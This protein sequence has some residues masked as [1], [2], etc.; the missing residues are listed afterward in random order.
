MVHARIPSVMRHAKIL[1][2]LAIFTSA[3]AGAGED[4][5]VAYS[6]YRLAVSNTDV[7]RRTGE[8]TGGDEM[9][10]LAPRQVKARAIPPRLAVKPFAE[11]IQN[12]ASRAALDPALVHAVIDVESRYNPSARSPKGA[13]GLMQVMPATGLR[14]G[15][16]NP[17]RSVEANLRAGTRY[18]SDL[19]TL[20]DGRLE[21]V[22]AAYNA[23]ENAVLRHGTRIPPYRETR[24]YVPAVLAR[25]RELQGPT[26]P[27]GPAHIEYL[28]GTRLDPEA[29]R[30]SQ[31]R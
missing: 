19:M 10:S 22:L 20:F 17:A 28:P 14:Y 4:G 3:S 30:D 1:L 24:E 16:P 21:L 12:A 2:L 8:E 5:P 13:L 29:L 31:A 25:Y 27:A 6:A 11:P 23:G 7:F 9:Y 26:P 15:V 18:L